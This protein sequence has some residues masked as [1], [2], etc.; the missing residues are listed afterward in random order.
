MDFWKT[1]SI[2]KKLIYSIIALT[3]L[4]ALASSAISGWMM[5][6][7]QS[8]AMWTKGHSLSAVLAEAA[9]SSYLSDDLGTTTGASERAL[10]FVKED[11]DVSIAA[12]VSVDQATKAA[13][14]KY[15]KRFR[16]DAKVDTAAL[17]EPLGKGS[18]KYEKNGFMIVASPLGNEAQDATRKVYQLLVLN[19]EGISKENTKSTLVALVL[20][21][22]MVGLGFVASQFLGNAIVSPLETI[23]H[24]MRDISEGEG[25][26]TA[27]LDVDGTDEIA[28]LSVNFN[29][30][31]ENI[32]GIVQQV[33]A[34]STNIASGSLQMTAGMTEMAS[35]ADAIAH[36]AENQKSSVRQAND[37]VGTIANSS[38][39]IYA[40]VSDALSVFDQ[41]QEAAGKGGTA[42]GA[43]VSGMQVIN[44]NSK[45]IGN[46]LNVITEIANQTNLLSLNAAIEAAK[47]G[48]HGKGFAVVAEEV[49]KLA[50]RSAQ[51]A[52]EITALIL[53]SSKSIDDGTSMVNTAGAALKS[54]EEAIRASAERM[55]TIGSQSQT[56]SQDS[57]T[58]V[59][60]MGSLS[61]IAEGNAAATEEM[62]ATIRETTRTVNELSHL[63]E[64]LNNLVSRFKV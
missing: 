7:T 32:Q 53:T 33:I 3:A 45:Q 2:R 63:A 23:Q 10:E 24:R 35:T 60:A 25:D 30:F 59:S 51:A 54:I 44:Q 19:T 39:V 27:R 57:T 43:A 14:V 52:K 38:K 18:D 40:T 28:Q 47:A 36:T 13:T 15:Q 48:E 50:E 8:D 64:T 16:A 58:V 22:V 49:R 55:K 20:L 61:S 34:I 26:L 37:S 5:H 17:A 12:I 1:L 41:A 31:V 56:Q 6:A 42:V 29:R 62:A 9:T 11:K 21:A 4:L 46:I